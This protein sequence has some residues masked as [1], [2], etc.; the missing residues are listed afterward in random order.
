MRTSHVQDQEFIKHL[1]PSSILEEA[2]EFIKDNFF[3]E[4]IFEEDKL[5]QWAEE[6]GYTKDGL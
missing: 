3:V 6:N 2:I 5:K 4:D 1:I